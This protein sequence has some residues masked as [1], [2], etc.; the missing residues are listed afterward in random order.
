MHDRSGKLGRIPRALKRGIQLGGFLVLSACS[1]A[2]P[3]IPIFGS[4]FPAWIIAAVI[5]IVATILIRLI[6]VAAGIDEHLPAPLL[7]YISLTLLC[8]IG[9]W[10]V[11]FGGVPG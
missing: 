6:L 1:P 7:V 8:G 10:F 11:L 3:A 4:Y 2:A 9:A 5:G